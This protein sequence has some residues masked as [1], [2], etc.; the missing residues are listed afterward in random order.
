M[1]G[2]GL[3]HEA[4]REQV[5]SALQLVVH[6]ARGADGRRRVESVAEVVRVAGGAATRELYRLRGDRPW[7]RPPSAGPLADRLARVRAGSGAG[8][9]ARGLASRS[10]RDRL[11]PPRLA[12]P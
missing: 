2:V 3:P 12:S 6:Q 5:A 4:V 1:A 8:P 7:W 10:P 11:S 9:G